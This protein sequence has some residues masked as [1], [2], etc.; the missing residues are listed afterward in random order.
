[1]I[2]PLIICRIIGNLLM[3]EAVAVSVCLAASWYYNETILQ[4]YIIT[5]VILLGLGFMLAYKGRS[6]QKDVSKKDGY[7]VVALCWL[8]F[9]AF[10]TLPFLFSGYIPNITDAFFEAVSGAG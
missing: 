3:L 6:T 8:V 9:P 10:A 4:A 1:M 7:I 2:H 5:L